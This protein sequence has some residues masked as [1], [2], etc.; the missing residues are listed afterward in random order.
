MASGSVRVDV[1]I[2]GLDKII[3]GSGHG[4]GLNG[5]IYRLR[6]KQDL[7]TEIGQ[8]MVRSTK[9]RID[10]TK[11]GPDGEAWA[12]LSELTERLKARD[13][14]HPGDILFHWGTLANSIYVLWSSNSGVNI[15]ADTRRA[16]AK[17]NYAPYMQGG[18]ARTG[19]R[20]KNRSVPARP[21]MGISE[22]NKKMITKMVNKYVTGKD[23]GK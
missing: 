22:Q 4:D 10:K 15:T 23:D 21:F 1:D 16:G 6:N 5:I 9:L 17:T 2:S 13:G 3:G 20:F 7:M 19:G 12:D 8:Y 14:V 11:K 18:V